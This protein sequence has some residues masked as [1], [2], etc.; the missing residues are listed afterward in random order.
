[1]TSVTSIHAS[2]SGSPAIAHKVMGH[3]QNCG[4]ESLRRLQVTES[5]RT[6]TLQ[7]SVPSYYLKQLAQSTALSVEGVARVVNETVVSRSRHGLALSE[8]V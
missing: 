2:H 6:V 3:L 7:G 4:H 8:R 1:V 5:A